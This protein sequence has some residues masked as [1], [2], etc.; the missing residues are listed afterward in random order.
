MSKESKLEKKEAKAAKTAAK[1]EKAA[2]K[3]AAKA[4]KKHEKDYNKFVKD[5]NKKN[6]KGANKPGFVPVA[7]PPIDEFQSKS[8]LRLEKATDKAYDAYVKKIEKKNAKMEAVCAKK[9]KPFVPIAVPTRDEFVLQENK[10]R[11]IFA[12]IIMILLIWLIVYFIVMWFMY[13]PPVISTEATT[14]AGAGA[15]NVYESY[16]NTHEITTTP[17]YSVSEARDFLKQVIH[18]NYEVI[19]YT[20]DASS[21]TISYS[22]KTVTVN[23]ANCYVFTCDG[24]TFAVPIKLSGCYVYQNGEYKPL[25]FNDTNY[26]FD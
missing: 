16:V 19:G 15:S 13:A 20:Y 7:I 3:A 14:D 12:T 6:A 5:A 9:G 11:K 23:N 26:L 17:D 4:S 24:K 10:K 21:S 18:D 25:T 8:E 2:Q 1:Q 22:N